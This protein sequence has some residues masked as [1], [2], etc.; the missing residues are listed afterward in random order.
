MGSIEQDAKA[1]LLIIGTGGVGTMAAHALETGG[2]AQVTAV[3]RSNYD[4]VSKKGINIDSLE[5]GQVKAWKPSESKYG[6]HTEGDLQF[7]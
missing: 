2:K 7:D 4:V 6:T 5:H 1:Q 3:M